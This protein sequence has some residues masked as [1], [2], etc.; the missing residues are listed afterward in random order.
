M[1][2]EGLTLKNLQWLI[3]PAKP[4]QTFEDKYIRSAFPKIPLTDTNE[5]FIS[6]SIHFLKYGDQMSNNLACSFK[7]TVN[8]L[9]WNTYFLKYKL[10]MKKK[11]RIL[12]LR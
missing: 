11:R 4:N 8:F 9:N 10:E 2:K 7:I 12:V 3:Y 5:W 1:Y 6:T